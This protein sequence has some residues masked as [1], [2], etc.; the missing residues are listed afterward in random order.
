MAC[1]L[2][3]TGRAP[4]TQALPVRVRVSPEAVG[5]SPQGLP[6]ARRQ[7]PGQEGEVRRACGHRG[8]SASSS[9]QPA[10]QPGP[11]QCGILQS[12]DPHTLLSTEDLQASPPHPL[13]VRGTEGRANH[14]PSNPKRTPPRAGCNG[15]QLPLSL[16]TSYSTW[17]GV[18]RTGF[19]HS[20][21][22]TAAGKVG[23]SDGELQAPLGGAQILQCLRS[24]CPSLFSSPRQDRPED[25]MQHCCPLLSSCLSFR[26]DR[27]SRSAGGARLQREGRSGTELSAWGPRETR[28]EPPKPGPSTAT[29][30]PAGPL[31]IVTSP[32][33]PPRAP[34]DTLHGHLLSLVLLLLHPRPGLS[35]T[36]SCLRLSL[37]VGTVQP[38]VQR[39]GDTQAL[40]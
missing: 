28:Q 21:D 15:W 1:A 2:Q 10:P 16:D 27:G 37:G 11:G 33:S 6:M 32:T 36:C 40:I 4:R 5:S 22:L 26:G 12:P 9:R 7:E 13:E 35:S 34:A 25:K 24:A 30:R 39:T 17:R 23:R 20:P 29:S 31:T 14:H 8:H 19:C 38:R 3:L 18:R